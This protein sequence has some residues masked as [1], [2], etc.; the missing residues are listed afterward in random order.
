MGVVEPICAGAACEKIRL[1]FRAI[2]A[3]L[4]KAVDGECWF[5]IGFAML[6]HSFELHDTETVY[7]LLALCSV[8][9]LKFQMVEA[10]T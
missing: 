1:A 2:V 6:I 9:W 5:V 4:S 8:Y 10:N 7:E 3:L